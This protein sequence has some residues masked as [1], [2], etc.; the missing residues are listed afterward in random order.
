[1]ILRPIAADNTGPRPMA[2]AYVPVW[3]AIARAQKWPAEEWWLIAQP[4]HAALSGALAAGFAAQGFPQVEESVARAI[5]LHDA[6]WAIFSSEA[7]AGAPPRLDERGCPLPFFEVPPPDFLRAW[8]RSVEV[9]EDV[10]RA[11]GY[12]VS[13]HFAW[14]GEYRLQVADDPPEIRARIGEFIAQQ[15]ARQERLRP[16]RPLER[17]ESLVTVLQFCDL[18]SLYLCSGSQETV[19]FPQQFAAGKVRARAQ[20]GAYHLQPSPFAANGGLSVAV[21]ARRYPPASVNTRTFGFLVW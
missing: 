2:D 12:I 5:G 20:D 16:D 11:G 10:C 17:L 13:R 6:G 1:M 8:N 18:L 15:Q 14:L 7:D 3:E 9:A 4:D 21:E 19:E